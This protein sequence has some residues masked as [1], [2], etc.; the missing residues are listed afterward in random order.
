MK[1]TYPYKGLP[2]AQGLYRPEHEHDACG[3]GFIADIEG[4]KSHE[5]VLKGIEILINLTHRGACG[6]DPQ[7]G[8]GAGILI[9]IPH[10]FFDREC[11]ALGFSLP[12][13]GEYGVGMMFLPVDPHERLLCEG[14][15]ERLAE[16]G[17]RRSGVARSRNGSA[18]GR[19]AQQPTHRADL[20][21]ARPG[22]GPGHARTQT[23]RGPQARRKHHRG[24]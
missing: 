17:A 8:D 23:V 9:Q 6:C 16:E 1:H 22:Y 18:I 4:R 15:I 3:I 10:A 7:T 21:P 20:Y 24:V 19:L 13:P 14:I 12:A 11:K 2:P 5:I